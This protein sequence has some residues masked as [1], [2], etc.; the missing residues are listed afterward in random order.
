MRP[1]V[2]RR[3][4]DYGVFESLREMKALIEREVERRE[5]ADH[6]KLGPGGI[7]EIEFIV[8]AFQ[9]IRGGRLRQ[10]QTPSLLAVLP[11]STATSCCRRE[12]VADLMAAY[13]FLRRLENRLQM[14]DD[15]QAHRL[16]KDDATRARIALA[17]GAADWAALLA[18][19]NAHRA[20]VA[21]HFKAVV[22]S[23]GAGCR[24]GAAVKVDLG[25]FW[26][27]QAEEAALARCAGARRVRANPA[28]R[29]ACCSSCAL[30]RSCAGSMSRAASACRRCCRCWWPT[31]PPEAPRR[32]PCCAAC[33]KVVEAIG[34]RS[35]YF[36]LLQ[37]SGAARRRLVELC[38]ARRFPRG[39]DRHASAAAR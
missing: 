24:I 23:G 34:Q 38:G 2:Y 7:R 26:D 10:L 1:F 4:L 29:R 15:A 6:V 9:L 16:P 18:Q 22:L 20:A 21:K 33:C 39:P 27:T 31:S 19:L 37:E 30:Q 35:V 3:Y 14:L 25:R 32:C 17:M 12:V 8:Q 36:A 28:K 13:A 11:C 5:L